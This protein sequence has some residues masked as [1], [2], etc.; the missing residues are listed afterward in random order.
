MAKVKQ[1]LLLIYPEIFSN[2]RD[3]CAF[4][5]ISI[6]INA[7]FLHNIKRKDFRLCRQ[8]D[9]CQSIVECFNFRKIASFLKYFRILDI[10]NFQF[11]FPLNCY[12]KNTRLLGYVVQF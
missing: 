9:S 2:F 1:I 3:R 7:L 8:F 6:D 12:L 5:R 4:F 10:G 11:I